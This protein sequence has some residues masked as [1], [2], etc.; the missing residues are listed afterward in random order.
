[1]VARGEGFNWRPL[2]PESLNGFLTVR[3]TNQDLA[4]HAGFFRTVLTSSGHDSSPL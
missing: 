2:F 1:M 4:V 3:G